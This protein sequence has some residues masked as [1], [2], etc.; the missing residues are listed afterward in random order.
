VIFGRAGEPARVRADPLACRSAGDRR[1]G[2]S[3]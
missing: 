3:A 1:A 2:T